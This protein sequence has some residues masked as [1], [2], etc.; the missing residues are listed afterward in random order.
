MRAARG[1]DNLVTVT[2]NLLS[3]V[4]GEALEL[5]GYWQKHSQHGWQF[6]VENFRSILPTTTQGIRKY[7]GSG[8]IKG[9]GPKTADKIVATFDVETL[10][11]LDNQPERLAEVPKLG[12]H[13][14]GLIAKAWVEQKAIKEVMVFLQGQ[15]VSTSLAV[16]IYKQTAMPRSQWSRTNLT[17]WPERFGV[18]DLKL[19]TRSPATWASARIT[20]SG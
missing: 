3:V 1:E 2:G 15:G 12:Q 7:L 10:D 6:K 14:A 11:I 18:S 20:W 9:I 5:T 4:E 16:R 19:R 13:K 17:A 8:L